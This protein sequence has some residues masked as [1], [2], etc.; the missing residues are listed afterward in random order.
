MNQGT[1]G[2]SDEQFWEDSTSFEEALVERFLASEVMGLFL[3]GPRLVR[4]GEHETIP[5]LGIRASTIRDDFALSLQRRAVIVTTWLEGHQTLAATAFRQPDELRAPGR[6]RDPASLPEGRTADA[7][8]VSLTARLPELP[9]KPGTW[10]TTLLLYDCCSNSVITRL[11]GSSSQ[12]PAVQDFLAAQRRPG[13]PAPVTPTSDSTSS[14]NPYRP[15]PD[16]PAPPAGPAIV[17]AIDRVV[18]ESRGRSC[19]LRGSFCLPVLPRDVV[20][21]LPGPPGSEAEQLARADGWVDVGDPQA[22]AVVPISIL[23]TG[24]QRAEPILLSLQIPIY[25]PLEMAADGQV[26]RGHF[27]V[28]LFA[29]LPD[30]LLIQSY[31]VWA[32]SR[33][34]LSAPVVVGVVSEAMLPAAGD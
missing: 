31:A 21:P 19:V 23:L 28:D 26:A 32:V 10:Q 33:G 29:S 16:S 25:S 30:P 7:F 14:A 1:F 13:Y 15:R 12:D 3:D 22:V 20:R 5:L 4:L 6:P 8:S 27:A 24:D 9:W 34:I 17:L 2:L 18:I 11:D